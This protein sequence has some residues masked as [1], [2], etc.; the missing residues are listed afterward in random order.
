MDEN[1]VIHLRLD[2]QKAYANELVFAN[3]KDIIDIN[4]KAAAYPARREIALEAVLD[5]FINF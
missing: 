4:M 3:S 2:K 5:W 1:C